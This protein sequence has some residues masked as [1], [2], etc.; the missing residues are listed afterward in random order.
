[1]QVLLKSALKKV[2][3]WEKLLYPFIMVDRFLNYG[4]P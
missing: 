3:R 2:N 4:H 1:M